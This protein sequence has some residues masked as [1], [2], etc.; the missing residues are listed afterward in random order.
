MLTKARFGDAAPAGL[1]IESV[2]AGGDVVR[3]VARLRL[4]SAAC[5][6]CGVSSRSAHSHYERRL[7]DLPAHGR[8][9][10]LRVR[11]RRFRCLSPRC[12]R[13]IFA[14]RLDPSV[15]RRFG[16]RMERHEG[17]VRHIGLVLGGRPGERTASRLLIP[18][19]KDT[20]LRVVRRGAA[21]KRNL[22]RV[23]GIDDWAWRKGHR[24][25]TLICDLERR[26]VIDLLPDREAATAAAW[27]AARPSIEIVARDR[28]GGYG[29]AARQGRPEAKQ[30]ADR[31][32]LMENA[33]ATFLVAVRRHMGEARRA[34]GQGPIDPATLTA[35]ER[36]QYEGWRRRVEDGAA[37]LALHG[38]GGPSHNHDLPPL[39]I[40]STTPSDKKAP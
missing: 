30:V 11:I 1:R 31:W 8:H 5:P 27:L 40:P 24:Y 35:A 12:A 28:G 32:H 19:S 6:D 4:A 9:V 20:L 29:S 34:V 25:G 14:E 37:V 17:I 7:A 18:A 26:K 3:L 15:A 38:R 39:K 22:P 33:S 23:I 36:I 2:E 13:K 16:R 21:P 10:R